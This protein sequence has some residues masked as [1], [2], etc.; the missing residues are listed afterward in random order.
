MRHDIIWQSD[1]EVIDTLKN[2]L[3]VFDIRATFD[4]LKIWN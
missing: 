1:T 3:C 2:G 4:L